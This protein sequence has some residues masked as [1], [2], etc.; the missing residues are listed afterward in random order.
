MYS[1]LE[2]W[3]TEKA[4]SA[5]FKILYRHFDGVIVENHINIIH[6]IW[7]LKLLIA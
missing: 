5:Y 3:S 2:R 6:G 1:E 4:N 7:Q